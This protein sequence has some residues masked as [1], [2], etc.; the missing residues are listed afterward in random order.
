[1]KK[2]ISLLLVLVMVV[3]VA[4]GCKSEDTTPTTTA[5]TAPAIVNLTG[6]MEEVIAAIYEKHAAVQLPLMTMTLDL[7]DLDALGYHTGLTSADKVSEIAISEP[8]MGQP[9]SL[10]LVRVKNAAD[11][12]AIAQEMFEKID[13]R[14]WVCMEADT[15]I[16][17][18]YGD[19]AM[20]FMVN[21]EFKEQVTTATMMD[22]FKTVCGGDVTVIQ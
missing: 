3:S 13:T 7:A 10:L 11:A 1:M 17:A 2:L 19:V 20:F 5:P 21:T 15:K 6:T 4:A 14:K 9:Y 18:S 12:N 16:A 22:A 8:M